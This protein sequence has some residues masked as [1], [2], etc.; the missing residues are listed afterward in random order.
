[1]PPDEEKETGLC[2]F[3]RTYPCLVLEK[4]LNVPVLEP[5]SSVC[6]E[7]E[8][9]REVLGQKC[10]LT[11]VIPQSIGMSMSSLSAVSS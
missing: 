6:K 4:Q 8:E 10:F 11:S 5:D 1:M 2:D 7:M 3:L 9:D